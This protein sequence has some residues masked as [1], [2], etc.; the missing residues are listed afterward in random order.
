M[1]GVGGAQLWR[2][3]AFRDVVEEIVGAEYIVWAGV[4]PCDHVFEGGDSLW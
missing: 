2:H 3:I 1:V 4:S